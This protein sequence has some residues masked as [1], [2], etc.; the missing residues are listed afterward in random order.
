MGVR[1]RYV[2]THTKNN[3]EEGERFKDAVLRLID[4]GS[5]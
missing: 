3:V 1:Q 5:D 2:E 4:L